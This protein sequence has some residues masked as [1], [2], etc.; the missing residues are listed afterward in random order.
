M[1]IQELE[2]YC[3]I[4]RV[5]RLLSTKLED[6][7]KTM[8]VMKDADNRVLIAATV[9]DRHVVEMLTDN[10]NL[11][12]TDLDLFYKTH[13]LIREPHPDINLRKYR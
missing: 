7:P 12:V 3:H 8:V 11:T 2:R 1:K 13:G 9:K 10:K 4:R 5:K 6:I